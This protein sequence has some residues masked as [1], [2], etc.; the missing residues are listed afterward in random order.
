MKSV[1]LVAGAIVVI[2]IVTLTLANLA[3]S[4]VEEPDV[5]T[6]PEPT[7]VAVPT[8]TATPPSGAT[9]TPSG[10]ATPPTNDGI[11]VAIKH[12]PALTIEMSIDESVRY[13]LADGSSRNIKLLGTE[14]VYSVNGITVW[15][16]ATVEVSGPGIETVVTEIG[17]SFFREPTEIHN[18]RMWVAITKEFNDGRLRDGGATPED[19]RLV[20]SD[21]RLPL[22][23]ADEFFYPYPDILWGEGARTT[24]SQSLQGGLDDM[25]HHRDIDIGMPQ[26]TRVFAWADGFLTANDRGFDW[27]VELTGGAEHGILNS[28]SVLH[29]DDVNTALDGAFIEKGE[30]I[31]HSGQASWFHTHTVYGYEFIYILREWYL[32]HSSPETLSYVQDWLVAGPF[33]EEN[34]ADRLQKDFIG[35]AE[36]ATPQLDAVAG[37]GERWTY[38]D[39]L[40][41]GVIYVSETV[42]PFP[43]SGFEDVI[44]NRPE[45]AVYMSTYVYSETDQSVLLNVGASDA[46]SVWFGGQRVLNE[47]RC[48][49]GNIAGDYGQEATI[50]VDEFQVPV[51]LEPGWNQVLLRTAQRNN[52][53]RAFQVSLRVSDPSGAAIDGLIVDPLRGETKPE[54]SARPARPLPVIEGAEVGV[55]EPTPTPDSGIAP[56]PTPMATSQP[57]VPTEPS[58]TPPDGLDTSDVPMFVLFGSDDNTSAGGMEFVRNAFESRVNP[59]G[60]GDISTF[61]NQPINMSFYLIGSNIYGPNINDSDLRDQYMAALSSGHE[62]GSHGFYSEQQQAPRGTVA[63]WTDWWLQPTNSAIE[64]MFIEYGL[65]VNDA[66]D[67]IRGFRSPQD[68]VD[69]AL[70]E[71]LQQ[72]GFEYG[73]SSHTNDSTNSPAWWPGTLDNGWPGGATWDGRDFGSTPGFWEI[74]QTYAQGTTRSCDSSW[75]DQGSDNTGADWRSAIQST[76]IDLYHGNR[77][78]LSIC[79]HSQNFGPEN[80]LDNG[81]DLEITATI[82]ERQEAFIQLLDWML[83]SEDFPDIRIVSHAEF[84]DWMKDP[85]PFQGSSVASNLADDQGHLLQT[86]NG[87]NDDDPSDSQH[88]DWRYVMADLRRSTARAA[89]A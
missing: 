76:L 83:D 54:P 84:L 68:V 4:D 38:W 21:A 75:F 63:T 81:G 31:G 51:T 1:S 55:G 69:P 22:T 86:A 48:V 39:N 36:T 23:V 32:A 80:T 46:V 10:S 87:S 57:S 42:S 67:A 25:F 14:L 45:S 85:A 7:T 88:S 37:G 11:P 58:Q 47:L 29:L 89:S 72:M 77:A 59:A 30:L 33:E 61:D 73:N 44:K 2:V 82:A 79:I 26:G 60:D 15:T 70:Y 40:V 41:P 18:V 13:V 78:P 53:P 35:G 52:C 9:P 66:Q 65:T 3:V 64:Q 56:T 71:A 62:L 50:L 74:P 6:T 12:Y 20:L 16:T 8:E 27:T 24:Y 19:A 28:M 49:P 17:S 5:F 43:Y 34:E